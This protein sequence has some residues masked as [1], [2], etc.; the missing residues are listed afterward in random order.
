MAFNLFDLITILVSF[1]AYNAAHLPQLTNRF[2]AYSKWI[3]VALFPKFKKR[4]DTAEKNWIKIIGITHKN[5]SNPYAI[6]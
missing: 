4:V 6:L 2:T 5:G 3:G 1:N